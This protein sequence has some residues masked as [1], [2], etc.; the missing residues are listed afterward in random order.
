MGSDKADRP[1]GVAGL[2]PLLLSAFAGCFSCTGI[3]KRRMD[4]R[5]LPDVFAFGSIDNVASR[6]HKSAFAPSSYK[7]IYKYSL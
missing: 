5:H 3:G 4:Y 2:T 6:T 7:A 1:Y